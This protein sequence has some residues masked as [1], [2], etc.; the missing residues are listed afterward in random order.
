MGAVTED[1]A[2]EHHQAQ[3]GT[4][5]EDLG[6]VSLSET[7]LQ[8]CFTTLTPLYYRLRERQM[9]AIHWSW[10]E[11][12][13]GECRTNYRKLKRG[14]GLQRAVLLW[15]ILIGI[16]MALAIRWGRCSNSGETGE[17]AWCQGVK[18]H[19]ERTGRCDRKQPKSAPWALCFRVELLC[20][21]GITLNGPLLFQMLLYLPLCMCHLLVIFCNPL[22]NSQFPLQTAEQWEQPVLNCDVNTQ[23]ADAKIRC[24][25]ERVWT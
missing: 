19:V 3:D 25:H 10:W 1:Q 16:T 14:Q 20:V 11:T 12:C 8:L 2:Q 15:E 5:G 18:G 23:A 9:E 4:R 17:E 24:G 7:D 21:R 6:H 22:I 13:C